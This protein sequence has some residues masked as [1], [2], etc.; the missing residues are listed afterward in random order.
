MKPHRPGSERL[1]V[2]SARDCLEKLEIC[3]CAPF[4][5]DSISKLVGVAVVFA[6]V[7]HLE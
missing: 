6:Q 3:Q 7:E 5:R 4:G 1:T 2:E